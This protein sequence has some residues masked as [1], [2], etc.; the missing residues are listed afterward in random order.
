MK[1]RH[2][3]NNDTQEHTG[4]DKAGN[5]DTPPGSP[6]PLSTSGSNTSS[7][8]PGSSTE[9]EKE[10]TKALMARLIML[11]KEAIPAKACSQ[12]AQ[13][14][15]DR[16]RKKIDEKLR[17]FLALAAAGVAINELATAAAMRWMNQAVMQS[18]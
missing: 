4:K 11:T 8:S 17:T 15:V 12:E 9:G 1:Y 10:S 7:S 16:I 6:P 5:T 2:A 18:L 13:D 14:E 3:D